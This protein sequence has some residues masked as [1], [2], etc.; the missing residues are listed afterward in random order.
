MYGVSGEERGVE[1]VP[2]VQTFQPEAAAIL[3]VSAPNEDFKLKRHGKETPCW[4]KRRDGGV[5]AAVEARDVDR[6]ASSSQSIDTCPPLPSFPSPFSFCFSFSSPP[7]PSSLCSSLF[8]LCISVAVPCR[9]LS[10]R[11]LPTTSA[12]VSVSV[13]SPACLVRGWVWFG[14]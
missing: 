1:G 14:Q 12:S 4:V 7:F 8:S 5:S 6:E 10:T 13:E 11:I 9:C 3:I 2:G